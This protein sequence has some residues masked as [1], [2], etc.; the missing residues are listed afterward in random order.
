MNARNV[1][2]LLFKSVNY[3]PAL[4]KGGKNHLDLNLC[5]TWLIL[6]LQNLSRVTGKERGVEISQTA[7]GKDLMLV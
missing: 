4:N 2:A 6:L 1:L 3:Y 5:L 7:H